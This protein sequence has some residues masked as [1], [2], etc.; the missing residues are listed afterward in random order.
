VDSVGGYD[1]VL[2]RDPLVVGVARRGQLACVSHVACVRAYLQTRL[3][4]TARYTAAGPVRAT[5]PSDLQYC[6][7]GTC[8]EVT[9]SRKV[10]MFV[11]KRQ[12]AD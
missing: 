10:V 11:D 3:R 6:S 4:H 12:Q 8:D 5:A 2:E 7:V 9:K 1:V